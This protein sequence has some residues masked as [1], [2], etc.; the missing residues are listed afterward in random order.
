MAVNN[1]FP[2]LE[3]GYGN[4][5]PRNA[6]GTTPDVVEVLLQVSPTQIGS[7]DQAALK[8]TVLRNNVPVS[9]ATVTFTNS[10]PSVA[11]VP[12]SLVTNA[13]GVIVLSLIGLDE[14]S[15]TI[16]ATYDGTSSNSS[17]LTVSEAEAPVEYEAQGAGVIT[18]EGESPL[19]WMLSPRVVRMTDADHQSLFPGDTIYALVPQMAEREITFFRKDLPGPDNQ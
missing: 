6:E 4:I 9:S 16:T 11:L 8:V 7:N 17:T 1:I 18:V 14:G 3:N 10:N 15:T 2:R 12:S 5:G 13:S 19:S